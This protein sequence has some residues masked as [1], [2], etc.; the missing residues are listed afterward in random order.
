VDGSSGST[1]ATAPVGPAR[2]NVI[3]AAAAERRSR[4]RGIKLRTLVG[5]H[6]GR[7]VTADPATF[8]PGTSAL[9]DDDLAWVLVDDDPARGLG[10][11]LAWARRR[12]AH[13]LHVLAEC[14]TG[15]LARRAAAFS[16]PITVWHVDGRTLEPA[17][18]ASLTAPPGPNPA[19]L[20]LLPVIEAGGATPV[21]EHGVVIGEVRGLEVCR[22]VDDPV[23]DHAR[24]EVGIGVHD[25]EAFA[26]IH[27]DIPTADALA[28]VV[29]AVTRHRGTGADHALDRLVPERLLRWRLEQ[30]SGDLGLDSL[31][32]AEP[33]VPRPNVKER[34]P[35]SARGR[36]ADG[37]EVVVVCSVG[38][39]LDLIPYA[40]DAR[41]LGE[42]QPGVGGGT[43]ESA[44]TLIVL[45]SR[46]LVPITVELAGL[47]D[48]AVALV[49]WPSESSS[50]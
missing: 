9:V 39:D 25:R 16:L 27:G 41:R 37:S 19:H 14:D 7:A 30:D 12:D 24:L 50:G 40:T 26:L 13:A 49:S 22:V 15:L 44:E 6:L 36:R 17:S 3:D 48:Q 28:G 47:L 29:D 23:D 43:M 21:I 10:P 35:C 46:D 18:A 38:V 32:P 34:A 42:S 8:P 31:A 11:A 45:P 20:S 5:D 1:S 4:L 2:S 33:P